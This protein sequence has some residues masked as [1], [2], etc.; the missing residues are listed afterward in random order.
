MTVYR[1]IHVV[2]DGTVS[3]FTVAGQYCTVYM[4]HIFIHPFVCEWLGYFHIL[5]IVNSAA[6]N[7]EVHV[8]LNHG[9]L[10]ICPGVGLLDHM[11]ALF[12]VF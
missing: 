6:V 10:Q 11:V 5:V 7:V 4:S 1:S 2:A 12:L 8:F 9:S 3:F